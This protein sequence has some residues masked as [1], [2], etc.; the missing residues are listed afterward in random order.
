M[1]PVN[2][3][4]DR[5]DAVTIAFH[6]ATAV[7][8]VAQW[9]GAQVID[10]FPAGSPRVDA[11]SVH[12]TG[13][14]LL[15]VLLLMRLAW[16]TTRGRRLPLADT[17]ALNL[18]AKGTHWGL[19]ALLVMMVLVGMFL[20]WVRGDSL[21]NLFSIPAY[22]P[23]NRA[24]SHQVQELHGTIGWMILAL[25]GLHAAAALVHRYVWR[26]AVLGRMLPGSWARRPTPVLSAAGAQSQPAS[27]ATSAASQAGRTPQRQP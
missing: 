13:G 5:Y 16:R 7:L 10:V 15:A 17:G 8:V 24:L 6:W 1:Q 20:V 27:L 4:A 23:G 12:I 26:D 22:D 19:Y 21:F 3:R 14:L 2:P 25:A 9:I 11:R 18:L